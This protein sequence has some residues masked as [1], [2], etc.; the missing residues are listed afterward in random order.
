MTGK[1]RKAHLVLWLILVPVAIAGLVI[2]VVL[3]PGVPIH[4]GEVPG[5]EASANPTDEPAQEAE[6]QP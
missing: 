4:Q 2:A 3:R 6:A 5:L 1:Q